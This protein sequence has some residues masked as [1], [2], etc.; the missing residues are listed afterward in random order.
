MTTPFDI[1]QTTRLGSYELQACIGQGGVGSVWKALHVEH[2]TPVAVKI[3]APFSDEAEREMLRREVQA[4]VSLHH[5]NIITIYDFGDIDSP[6]GTLAKGSQWLAMELADHPMDAI[7]LSRWSSLRRL[8]LKLLS[9]L[10]H[11]HARGIIHRDLKP[12]NILLCA[13]PISPDGWSPRIGDFGLAHP[14]ARTW[15]TE[16][17]FAPAGGTPCYMA[18]EQFAGRWRDYGPWTDLYA[19]GCIAYELTSGRPPFYDDNIVRLGGLH[20]HSPVPP[21]LPTLVGCPDGLES[22]LLKLLAKHPTDRFR[23]AADARWALLEIAPE[24]DRSTSGVSTIVPST[25][26]SATQLDVHANTLSVLSSEA[27]IIEAPQP[28]ETP[29]GVESAPPPLPVS[30]RSSGEVQAPW[31]GMGSKLF[32]LREVPFV[33]REAERDLIWSALGRIHAQ[34]HAEAILFSGALGCGK[35]RLCE[36]ACHR[37]EELGAAI[38][39]KAT[40][41]PV[42]GSSDGTASMLSR[43]LG[44]S[45]LQRARAFAQLQNALIRFGWSSPEAAHDAPALLE[46]MMPASEH[47]RDDLPL[48]RFDSNKARRAYLGRFL[49]SLAR[50]RPLLIFLDDV[51]WGAESISL[52]HHLL[53]GESP[54]LAL[55]VLTVREDELPARPL[56]QGLLGVLHRQPRAHNRKLGPLRPEESL[57]LVNSLL[58]LHPDTAQQL[59]EWSQGSPLLVVQRIADL[60][61]RDALHPG[62]QGYTA[63]LISTPD[64]SVGHNEAAFWQSRIDN[65]IESL[66]D[67]PTLDALFLAAFLGP[68]VT[69]SEWREASRHCGLERPESLLDILYQ[70]GLAKPTPNGFAFSHLLVART[71]AERAGHSG[72]AAFLHRICAQTIAA[73]SA[74]G[75]TDS[76]ERLGQH[77]LGAQAENE[78]LPHLLEAAATSIRQGALDRAS[79]LL[80]TCR[81]TL[82]TTRAPDDDPLRIA[83]FLSRGRLHFVR[84]EH[85]QAVALF[86]AVLERTSEHSPIRAEA[87]RLLGGSLERRG[88]LTEAEQRFSEAS[89]VFSAIQDPLGLC[90][91]LRDHAFAVLTL[92]DTERAKHLAR[93]ALEAARETGE[94]RR[95]AQCWHAIGRALLYEGDHLEAER[96]LRFSL[97]A[98]AQSGLP[99]AQASLYNDLGEVARG[100]GDLQAAVD[101][102]TQSRELFQRLGSQEEHTA[103]LNLC[104]L[105]VESHHYAAALPTLEALAPHFERQRRLILLTVTELAI[106]LCR[107]VLGDGLGAHQAWSDAWQRTL[108]HQLVDPDIGHL[109]ESL[110]ERLAERQENTAS[111]RSFYDLALGQWEQL[112]NASRV[113]AVHTR[114]RALANS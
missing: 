91:T 40:H 114:I 31:S 14:R 13:D 104:I 97:E 50:Q 86:R 87:L 28:R 56:E 22:W 39:L 30:W 73:R 19:L 60:L 23:C 107:L 82:D 90:K 113:D 29:V 78:A 101:A 34:P 102:Y 52:A 62:P 6:Q 45:G 7:E 43:L 4:V 71:L 98:Y 21:L 57:K 103:N 27:L 63:E 53:Q 48:F 64:P 49:R 93:N 10:A 44:V 55:L 83:L 69:L 15:K 18:P 38:A 106:A 61:E 96:T 76:L 5:P 70:R 2:Q 46:L 100:R 81:H 77:L 74:G 92:G 59:A 109:A 32:G 8:L 111:A 54:L 108:Q 72:R 47:A 58:P 65:L 66:P 42:L 95:I 25:D 112:A 9:A 24:D 88:E 35:S 16:Q 110:A 84:G 11:A 80:D 85:E 36:W 12:A 37:V 67:D 1:T 51:Q 26:A 3:I 94:R 33:G 79:G 89:A 68:R 41:S 20:T 105:N 17:V 75:S 99:H